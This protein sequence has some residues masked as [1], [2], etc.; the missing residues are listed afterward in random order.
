MIDLLKVFRRILLLVSSHSRPCKSLNLIKNR[1]VSGRLNEERV[2][3]GGF[4]DLRLEVW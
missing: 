2:E 1:Y 4:V 3:M